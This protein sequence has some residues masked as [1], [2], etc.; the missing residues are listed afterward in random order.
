LAEKTLQAKRYSQAIFEIAKERNEFD[1]WQEDL[2]KIAVLAQNSEFVAVMENPKF[3]IE[4]KYKLLDTRLKNSGP[5]AR[6]LA[7]ILAG[8]GSFDL[9]T[10]IHT[11]YQKLLDSYR[12]IEQAEVTTAV[13]LDENERQKLAVRLGEMT[14]KK[15][16]MTMKV[17]PA[18]IG[19][20][21]AKVG[22][23]IIDGSTRS[24]LEALK[25]ELAR[26]G[27]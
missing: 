14:G 15:V 4:E 18:I 1:K 19:G 26:S 25:N 20:V 7:Y 11:D 2:H 27:S 23:K 12:G 24:Q 6:N 3:P 13:P 10:G 9:I 21:I 22:E 8:K 17:D 16:I 5:M